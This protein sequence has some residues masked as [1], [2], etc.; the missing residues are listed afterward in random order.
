MGRYRTIK[1]EFWSD[2]NMLDLSDSCALFY[3]SLWNFCDDEGKIENKPR[4]I[5][6]TTCR[7]SEGK[8]KLFIKTLVTSGRL[9]ISTDSTWVQVENWAHQK[10]DRPKQPKI[11]CAQIQWITDNVSTSS[12]RL[13]TEHSTQVEECKGK[14]EKRGEENKIVA[15]TE[16]SSDGFKYN[17]EEKIVPREATDLLDAICDYFE[18]RKVLTSNLYSSIDDFVLTVSHRNEL[19]IVSI[20]L[21]KYMSYKARSQETK[22]NVLS[23]IGTKAN[24]Y[25]DGQWAAIDWEL[26]LKNYEQ[27]STKG[28]PRSTSAKVGGTSYENRGGFGPPS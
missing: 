2:D 24:H 1:P 14:E 18:V 12:Q 26:K 16:I 10:I 27:Q 13:V 9:R 23:W 5:S 20:A 4:G 8:V 25:N 6:K 21:Q 22:H 17:V 7:W 11:L 19:K 28:T 15:D 3:V